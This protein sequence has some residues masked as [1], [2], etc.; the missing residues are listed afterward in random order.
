MQTIHRCMCEGCNK[1]IVEPSDGVIIQG[2]VCVAD[3]TVRG[4][5]IGNAF[6]DNEG[7][8]FTLNEV[9]EYSF[10]IDCLYKLLTG[11]FPG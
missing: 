4:G 5:L 8:T 7:G 10:H 2:N 1:L 6:P 11:K 3:P 9:K